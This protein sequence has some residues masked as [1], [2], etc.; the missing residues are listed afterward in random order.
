MGASDN[1]CTIKIIIQ[2][3]V[4]DDTRARVTAPDDPARTAQPDLGN[5]VA[6]TSAF[7]IGGI[8]LE[9]CLAVANADPA[10]CRTV[11]A[12]AA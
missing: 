1:V 10:K 6:A 5:G 7:A 4:M 8:G 3:G 9:W 2:I 11:G 12:I